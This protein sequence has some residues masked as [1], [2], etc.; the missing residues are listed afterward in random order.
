LRLRE[1]R[2]DGVSRDLFFDS[3]STVDI[4]HF[5]HIKVFDFDICGVLV[6][7][8]DGIGTGRARGK[9]SRIGLI[10]YSNNVVR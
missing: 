10:N 5:L 4:E 3:D 1:Q 9:G 7:D 2:A 8:G 6:G